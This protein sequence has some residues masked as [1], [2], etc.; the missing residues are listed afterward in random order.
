M[1]EFKTMLASVIQRGLVSL[2]DEQKA[3]LVRC[4]RKKIQNALAS[5]AIAVQ[6]VS[7]NFPW[8]RTSS[9]RRS[10]NRRARHPGRTQFD[11]ILVFNDFVQCVPYF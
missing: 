1:E 6:L 2:W 5:A 7:Q 3:P 9:R 4:G 10:S 11:R 8:N